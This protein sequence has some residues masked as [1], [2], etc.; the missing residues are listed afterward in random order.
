MTAEQAQ[1]VLQ[2]ISVIGKIAIIAVVLSQLKD[3]VVEI[4]AIKE[5]N[6]SLLSMGLVVVETIFKVVI[7]SLIIVVIA[8]GVEKKIKERIDVPQ[9]SYTLPH[10][11]D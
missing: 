10:S 9:Q 3:A 8:V 11:P 5:R 4:K 1:Q 7:Y 2:A 6:G